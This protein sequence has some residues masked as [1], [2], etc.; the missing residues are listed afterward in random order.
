MIDPTTPE[1]LIHEDGHVIIEF[2]KPTKRWWMTPEE[3]VSVAE[4]I[5]AAAKKAQPPQNV[6]MF[7][8]RMEET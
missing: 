1:L 5:L 3:A 6:V 7:S 2:S 4:S 8:T